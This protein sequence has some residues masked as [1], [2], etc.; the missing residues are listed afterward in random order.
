LASLAI[1]LPGFGINA[2]YEL[3]SFFIIIVGLIIVHGKIIF[4]IGTWSLTWENSATIR[5]GVDAE[6]S[7]ACN[8]CD[9]VTDH[10]KG[11]CSLHPETVASFLK[12]V[13]L[14]KGIPMDP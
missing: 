11:L 14:C 8:Y 5:G 12:L 4:L 3:W 1:N 6:Y 9:G 13:E 2:I 7:A 10:E